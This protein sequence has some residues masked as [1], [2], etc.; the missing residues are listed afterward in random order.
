MRPLRD[1][2]RTALF[3]VIKEL[4][5]D[6]DFLDLFA[7]TGAVGLEAL[8]RGAR[9]ATFVEQCPQVIRLIQKN[10]HQ[11]GYQDRARIMAG[12]A[13]GLIR[14][15][16]EEGKGFDLV[17]VGAP[18]GTELGRDA[19]QALA[20]WTPLLPGAVVVV[21]MQENDLLTDQ[22]SPLQ[23]EQSRSYGETQLYMFRFVP[24]SGSV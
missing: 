5:P 20:Q 17:Y 22:H 8:S 3:D 21:E 13:V 23:L 12:D 9:R 10:V 4:V 1:R 2:V 24:N 15:L 6:S 19:L 14:K 16:A 7:G 18:Y 11:L